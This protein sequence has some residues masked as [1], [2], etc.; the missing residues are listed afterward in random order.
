[1]RA[2]IIG[3]GVAGPVTA[4][5]LQRAGIEAV[6]FEAYPALDR[7]V[8]SYFTVSPNGLDALQAVD[9]LHVAKAAGFST[10]GNILYNHAGR[11]LGRVPLGAPLHDGTTA[12]TMKRSR[13]SRRLQQ[14]AQHRGVPLQWGKRLQQVTALGTGGVVATFE[15]GSQAEGDLLIG[16]DGVHSV[17][18]TIIDPD[19]PCARYVGLTN[20]GGVTSGATL[21]GEPAAWHFMFGR[22]AFFGAHAAPSGDVVW[23]ANVPGPEI[24]P[25]AR[26]ATTMAEWKQHLI[27]LFADDAGPAASLIAAGE[28]EL[29][30][31]NTYDLEH[32]PTWHRGTLIIIGDAAHAP[33]P[34]S[35]QGASIALEDAVLLAKALRDRS[36]IP[37]AFGAYE[38]QR[39]QRVERVVAFGARG[40]RSKMPGPLGRFGRDLLLPL[41]FRYAMTE[42]ALAWLYGHRVE[43][44][45]RLGSVPANDDAM[46]SKP[47]VSS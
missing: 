7:D 4:L 32:V 42:R 43:W 34:S 17:T 12:L 47:L 15:D 41:V 38:R 33:A 20:F 21:P 8:G 28:L 37:Q 5:A 39:R 31:D 29:A 1:V 3:G 6:V 27:A 40:S 25:A 44:D 9:A 24:D 14:E 22:R 18:R 46:G 13:L 2:L 11:E 35:G 26:A 30:G 10:R 23:F 36:S 45:R 19:A 16:A